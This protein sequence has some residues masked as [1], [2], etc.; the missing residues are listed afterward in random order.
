[1]ATRE[2]RLGVAPVRM[3]CTGRGWQTASVGMQGWG[4][5]E[6]GGGRALILPAPPRPYL[7]TLSGVAQLIAVKQGRPGRPGIWDLEPAPPIKCVEVV[8]NTECLPCCQAQAASAYGSETWGHSEVSLEQGDSRP[9]LPGREV[10]LELE[11]HVRNQ[12]LGG[13]F[14]S[15]REGPRSALVGMIFRV[16]NH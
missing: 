16:C 12:A 6:G 13:L 11:P 8:Q 15:R 5:F 14:G 3:K 10:G 4:P 9:T 1:M 2:Y 7:D